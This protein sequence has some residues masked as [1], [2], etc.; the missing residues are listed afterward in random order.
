MRLPA[1]LIL[2]AS[3]LFATSRADAASRRGGEDKQ[4]KVKVAWK[5]LSAGGKVKR[6]AW[7]ATK[8]A[9]ITVGILAATIVVPHTI[10]EIQGHAAVSE[11]HHLW[12]FPAAFAAYGTYRVAKWQ[13]KHGR[14]KK[15]STEAPAPATGTATAAQ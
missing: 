9:A 5:D 12:H 15:A 3:L 11:H 10:A 8:G 14:D 2:S 13:L 4:P 1:I 6:V 7:K